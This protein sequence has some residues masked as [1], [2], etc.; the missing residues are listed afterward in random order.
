MAKKLN[1]DD[2]DV[3]VSSLIY[4]MGSEAEKIFNY[5]TIDEEGDKEKYDVVMAKFDAYFVPQR[6]LIHGRACFY[7][8]NQQ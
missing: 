6:N 8:R 1:K 5:S 2:G 7:L 3:Q 4:A